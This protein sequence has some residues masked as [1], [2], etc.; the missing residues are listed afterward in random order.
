MKKFIINYIIFIFLIFVLSSCSSN[1]FNGLFNF[2]ISSIFKNPFIASSSNTTSKSNNAALSSQTFNIKTIDINTKIRG[3]FIT[4]KD[5]IAF[6]DLDT[7]YVFKDFKMIFSKKFESS[8]FSNFLISNKSELVFSNGNTL[9]FYNFSNNNLFNFKFEDNI[10]SIALTPFDEYYILTVNGNIIKFVDFKK[11]W[12]NSLNTSVTSKLLV[13]YNNNVVFGD[14][15]GNIYIFNSLGDKI[16][17]SKVNGSVIGNFASDNLGNIYVITSTKWLYVISTNGKTIWKKHFDNDRILLNILVDKNRNI[18][19]TTTGNIYMYNSNFKLV[20]KVSVNNLIAKSILTNKGIVTGAIDG[21]IFIFDFN[22]KNLSRYEIKKKITNTN[23]FLDDGKIY[24]VSENSIVSID[25]ENLRKEEL[26]WTYSY[27]LLNRQYVNLPPVNVR[28]IYPANNSNTL[29]KDKIKVVWDS[30]DL[31]GENLKYDLY[32]GTSKNNLKL[33]AGN[34][35]AKSYYL[36]NLDGNVSYFLKLAAKDSNFSI[37]SNT[38]Q[39]KVN[40]APDKPVEKNPVNHYTNVSLSPVLKWIARDKDSKKLLFNLYFG[41]SIDSLEKIA[42]G[43]DVPEFSLNQKLEPGKQYYW[44]VEVFDELGNRNESDVFDFVTSHAPE[45]PEIIFP[46]I[47]E[48]ISKDSTIVFASKD[49]DNDPLLY[50][51]YFGNNI[52]S[53]KKVVENYSENKIR[54]SEFSPGKRYKLKIAVKDGKGNYVESKIYD[55][56]IK[57]EPKL[58]WKYYTRNRIKGNG[59]LDDEGNIYIGNDSGYFY[60]LDSKGSIIWR[61]KTE[62]KIWST[63]LYA[64][65]LIYFGNNEGYLYALNKNGD[66]KWKFKSEDIITASPVIDNKGIIYIGSWDGYLYAVNPDGTLKWKFKTN[67]SISGSPVIGRSGTLYIGS[68]D[69][70]LY[71]INRDGTLRWKYKTENRISQTPALDNN[72]NIYIGSEDGYV[73]SLDY[74]G[75]L[76]WSFKT[77][78]YIKSSPVVDENGTIYIGGW[79][80]Y[81]YA[82]NSDGTLKWKFK[83]QYIIT[84]SAVLGDKGNIYISSYDHNIY[85]L[86]T[87]GRLNWKFKVEDIIDSNLLLDNN[88]LIFSDVSGNLYSIIVEDKGLN[89]KAQWPAFKKNNYNVGKIKIVKNLLPLGPD[90][91]EPSNG[92]VNVPTDITLSWMAYDMDGDKLEYTVFFGEDKDNLKVVLRNVDTLTYTP[93][94]L[95]PKT[96]YYWKVI[97]KDSRNAVKEGPIWSFKT[98]NPYGKIK[99]N[100]KTKGWIENTPLVL[101]SGIYFG[102]YDRYFYAVS[103]EGVLKWRFLTNSEIIASPNTDDGRNIYFGDSSGRLY[104]ITNDGTLNWK[105]NLRGKILSTPLIA[106]NRIYVGTSKGVLYS[107]DLNGNILWTFKTNDYILSMPAF[108]NG[109]IIFGG[110]DSYVYSLNERGELNWKFKTGGSVKSSPAIDKEG[111][112]YI[113]SDDNYL[114]K[115]SKFGKLIFKFRTNSSIQTKVSIDEN[116]NIYFGSLDYY[117]YVLNPKGELINKFKTDGEIYST[118]TFDDKGYIYFASLDSKVYALNKDYSI[119]WIFNSGYGIVSSPIIKDGILYITSRDGNLYAIKIEGHNTPEKS[120]IKN[121]YNK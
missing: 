22:K 21:T 72:E 92:E 114:Y 101:N 8:L 37:F 86:D 6:H 49:I 64:D 11:V 20:K 74:N 121:Y 51:I 25:I 110:S 61:F 18:Y 120:I 38:I 95:K 24:F 28:I 13:T 105:L 102:S 62:N 59:V 111:N 10:K 7:L 109:N 104:S 3:S 33:I 41:Q 36:E 80:N 32:F 29:I 26:Y 5:Y 39:F 23:I 19:L 94:K 52:D 76:R 113:G 53:L 46:D 68:W 85:C 82:I 78:S 118:P 84:G 14:I 48:A 108:Y 54:I 119:D 47:S 40:Y 17:T 112:I 67:N 100:Y 30:K 42:E 73:Y 66:L 9:Y 93:E 71:A 83:T 63:P 31:N 70:Y 57:Y 99:W 55:I 16:A 97:V 69:G 58:N 91:P 34:L 12:I 90:N 60:K 2:D 45:K 115:I 56:K 79:D 106:N 87:R 43:L 107:I 96:T 15:Q 116:G 65:N 35:S 4:Y 1:Y 81:L 50:D 98:V 103:F 88:N 77:E 27:G 89:E 117:L 75:N 44:K